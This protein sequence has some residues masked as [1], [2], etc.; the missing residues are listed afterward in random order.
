MIWYMSAI[1]RS[2]AMP[3]FEKGAESWAKSYFRILFGVHLWFVEAKL[4]RLWWQQEKIQQPQNK[5]IMVR[6]IRVQR[7]PSKRGNSLSGAP[8]PSW[9]PVPPCSRAGSVEFLCLIHPPVTAK[10]RLAR[11]A[12]LCK[13]FKTGARRKGRGRKMDLGL[14]FW[15]QAFFLQHVQK[16][17]GS[18]GVVYTCDDPAHYHGIHSSNSNLCTQCFTSCSI[19]EIGGVVHQT[20]Q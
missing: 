1:W 19:I 15:L 14:R 2:L 8:L 20:Q 7:W 13:E 18:F 9:D 3:I 5:L 6:R 17:R 11:Q 10:F 4:M 12:A 16:F